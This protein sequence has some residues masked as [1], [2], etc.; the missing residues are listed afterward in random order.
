MRIV[1]KILILLLAVLLAV[2]GILIYARTKVEPPIA[3]KQIDQ[4]VDDLAKCNNA[5]VNGGTMKEDDSAFVSTIVKIKVYEQ[6][7]K[8]S[9]ALA[10]RNLDKT[11]AY[12]TPIFLNFCFDDFH[13]SQWNDDQHEYMLRIIKLL[14]QIRH[15]DDSS[16]LRQSTSDS[17]RQV[18]L[19]I[20]DYRQARILSRSTR[21]TGIEAAQST[22]EKVKQ[23]TRDEYLSHCTDLVNALDGVRSRLEESHYQYITSMV[24]K[25]SQYRYFSKDYYEDTLVPQVNEAVTQYAKEAQKLYGTHQDV[26]ILWSRARAYYDVAMEYYNR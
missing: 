18:S 5:I 4:Y 17:L 22:I 7:G 13:Q 11:F 23:Y 9:S 6:E 16:V 14:M 10:D 24:E 2:G 20:A 12:F 1:T 15:S 8:M 19:I 21:F 25:L 26:N 3:V